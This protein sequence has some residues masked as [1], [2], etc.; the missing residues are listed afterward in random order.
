MKADR[1]SITCNHA[2]I[3][4]FVHHGGINFIGVLKLIK[5]SD[6]LIIT[7]RRLQGTS[8]FCS[9][10]SATELTVI[11]ASP[12]VPLTVTRAVILVGTFFLPDSIYLFLFLLLALSHTHISTENRFLCFWTFCAYVSDN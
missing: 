5:V 12:T 6:S 4:V 7:D 3:P 9:M 10:Q 8:Q 11:S 1:R 2:E